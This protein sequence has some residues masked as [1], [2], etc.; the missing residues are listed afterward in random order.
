MFILYYQDFGKKSGVSIMSPV[1]ENGGIKKFKEMY[2]CIEESLLSK[3]SQSEKFEITS[4]THDRT[5][6]GIRFGGEVFWRLNGGKNRPI[7]YHK[8]GE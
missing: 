2:E 5:L 4:S 1:M 6:K 3:Y 8:C 7:R